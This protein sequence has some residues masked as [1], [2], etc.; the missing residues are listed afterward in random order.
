MIVMEAEGIG[1]CQGCYLSSICNKVNQNVKSV[2]DCLKIED[3]QNR[4]H[5]A[6]ING[7][8]PPLKDAF[9]NFFW[10]FHDISGLMMSVELVHKA[11]EDPQSF[12]PDIN[13]EEVKNALYVEIMGKFCKLSEDLG[14]LFSCFHDD[15]F[16]FAENYI[17]YDIPQCLDFYKNHIP[18]PIDDMIHYMHYPLIDKLESKE[19]KELIELSAYQI[20]DYLELIKNSYL[21]LRKPYNSYKHGYRIRLIDGNMSSENGISYSGKILQ[22]FDRDVIKKDPLKVSMITF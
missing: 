4:I 17:Q 7:F 12:F 2:N 3:I 15:P 10:N 8:I 13:P 18:L 19:S 20:D 22:Y 14:G 16:T 9:S 21:D 11:Y 6:D 5:Y 1:I